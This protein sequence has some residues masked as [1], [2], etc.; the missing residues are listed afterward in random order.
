[1]SPS[2]TNSGLPDRRISL[3]AILP[4]PKVEKE[5]KED[6]I[7]EPTLEHR[8]LSTNSPDYPRS[9]D[10]LLTV[11]GSENKDGAI[12]M[13]AWPTYRVKGSTGLQWQMVFSF[14]YLVD[15]GACKILLC[16]SCI[17]LHWH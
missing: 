10:V 3:P 16:L 12:K 9:C 2:E 8:F 1:M 17:A 7:E 5:T 13:S 6:T 11:N 14:P 4:E 15:M